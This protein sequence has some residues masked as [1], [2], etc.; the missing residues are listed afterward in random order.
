M[1][2]IGKTAETHQEKVSEKGSEGRG[3][4]GRSQ[5]PL[6]HGMLV[7]GVGRSLNDLQAG[8]AAAAASASVLAAAFAAPSVEPAAAAPVTTSTA[9]SVARAASNAAAGTSGAKAAAA[10]TS[11][12]KAPA[13]ASHS[14]LAVVHS[15]RGT[16]QPSRGSEG[17][18]RGT[19]LHPPMGQP[20]TCFVIGSN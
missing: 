5:P 10:G 19:C 16:G 4:G 13:A 9:R 8:G 11:G 2:F 14:H 15:C 7:G 20:P 6:L 12:A 17:L 3:R 18:S 1:D